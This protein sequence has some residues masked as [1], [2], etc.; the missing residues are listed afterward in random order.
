[1]AKQRFR[2]RQCGGYQC[3]WCRID[4]DMAKCARTERV[5]WALLAALSFLVIVG[6]VVRMLTVAK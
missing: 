1:M 4:E 2:C 3:A 6:A 5:L